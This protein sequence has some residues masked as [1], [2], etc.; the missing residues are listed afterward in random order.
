MVRPLKSAWRRRSCPAARTLRVP[1]T[2]ASLYTGTRLCCEAERAPSGNELGAPAVQGVARPPERDVSASSTARPYTRPSRQWA[3][4]GLAGIVIGP[5][6]NPSW[7]MRVHS[8]HRTGRD[9]EGISCSHA[10]P[11]SPG[12]GARDLN[13]R[14]LS[15][16]GPTEFQ[17][18]SGGTQGQRR[19]RPF[20]R[21]AMGET[22]RLRWH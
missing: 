4:T 20:D 22:V 19:R 15:N 3:R 11:A 16:Q 6:R 14:G 17:A 21:R 12:R 7:S 18:L 9:P 8:N 2:G 1:P 5:E 10:F 13:S